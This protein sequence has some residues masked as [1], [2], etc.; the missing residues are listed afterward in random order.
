VYTYK[1]IVLDVY[2]G[3]TITVDMTLKRWRLKVNVDVGFDLRVE[4]GYLKYRTKVRLYGINTPEVR[5]SNPAVVD[6]GKAA[7]DYLRERVLGKEV[8]LVTYKDRKEKYGRYLATVYEG[9]SSVNTELV[10]LGH[11]SLYLP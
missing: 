10:S 11:A 1:A 7:R 6:A 9:G 5:D 4:N 8:T 3:D 2:D